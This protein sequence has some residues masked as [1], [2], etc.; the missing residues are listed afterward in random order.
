MSF[1]Q[2]LKLEPQVKFLGF[3][4]PLELKA[5]YTLCRGMVFPTRFEGCG[6]PIHE[7]FQAG[8]PVA[9]SDVTCLPEQADGAAL[10]FNPAEPVDMAEAIKALW[11]DDALCRVLIGKGRKNVAPLNWVRTAKI[12]RAHYRRLTHRAL[13]SEDRDL[14]SKTMDRIS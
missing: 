8:A 11:T 9:C 6:L 7:A 13:T 4:S 10:L 2:K 14:L 1:F 5:L 3:V 12:Y